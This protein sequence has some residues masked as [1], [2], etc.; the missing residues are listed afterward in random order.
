MDM[1]TDEIDE[2]RRILEKLILET[3]TYCKDVFVCDGRLE[4]DGGGADEYR[5]KLAK[6]QSGG[7]AAKVYLRLF[8][9]TD[10]V[11]GQWLPRVTP[12]NLI[13]SKAISWLWKHRIPAGRLSL[14]VGMPGVG[15]S[16]LTA[17]MAARVSTGRPWPDRGAAPGGSARTGQPRRPGRNVSKGRW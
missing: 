4:C 13:E 12:M 8:S 16:Y 7:L 5:E 15:K 1:I 9:D 11:N 6:Y 3:V 2:Q 14:L 17:D 10:V